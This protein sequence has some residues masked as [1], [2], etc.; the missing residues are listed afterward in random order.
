MS[1][2]LALESPIF[3]TYAAV[4]LGLLFLAGIAIQ[5][6]KRYSTRDVTHA[7]KSY[8]GWLI[9]VPLL[10]LAIF[11]GRIATVVFFM[12]IS[13]FGIKEFAERLGSIKIGG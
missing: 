6:L 8:C 7:W 4:I 2:S 12:L 1:P 10:L 13:I 5:L 11:L 9:M 3:R